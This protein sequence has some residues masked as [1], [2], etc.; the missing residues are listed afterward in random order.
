MFMLN[1]L[2]N[3][4]MLNIVWCNIIIVIR[5]PDEPDYLAREVLNYPPWCEIIKQKYGYQFQDYILFNIKSPEILHPRDWQFFC[6]IYYWILILFL[7][8][9]VHLQIGSAGWTVLNGT[10]ES[11]FRS[12]PKFRSSRNFKLRSSQVQKFPSSRNFKFPN[13]K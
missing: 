6:L 12:S 10:P 13:S 2:L 9:M 5:R 11:E 1:V 4:V 8:C 7:F 3:T